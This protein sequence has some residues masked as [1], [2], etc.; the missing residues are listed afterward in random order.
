[1]VGKTDHY[2]NISKH[3]PTLIKN[4]QLEEDEV[5]IAYDVSALFTGVPV[6]RAFVIIDNKLL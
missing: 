5:L 6:D 2:V 4:K 1:M 3:F